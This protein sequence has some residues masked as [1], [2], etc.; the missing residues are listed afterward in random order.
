MVDG[1][2]LADRRGLPELAARLRRRMQNLEERSKILRE[3]F[4]EAD[5]ASPPAVKRRN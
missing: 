3:G 2:K 1:A 4:L 5:E